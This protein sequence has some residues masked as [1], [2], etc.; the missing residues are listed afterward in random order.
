MKKV[1]QNTNLT[2]IFQKQELSANQSLTGDIA[3]TA[4][5]IRFIEDVKESKPHTRNPKVYTGELITL[6]HKPDDTFQF[7]FKTMKK[8]FDHSQFAFQVYTELTTALAK[9]D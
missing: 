1:Y 6:V 5:G 9:L 2:C 7:N 4:D 8:G 3:L